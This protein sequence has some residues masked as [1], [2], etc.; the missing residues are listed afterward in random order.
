MP[1][2]VDVS[3]PAPGRWDAVVVGSGIGGLTAGALYATTGRRVLVLERN[4]SF[5]GAASVYR[6]G[7]LTIEASL[8]ELDGLDD[9]DVKAPIFDRLGVRDAIEFVDVGDLYEVRSRLLEEPFR[10]PHGVEAATAALAARFPRHARSFHTYFARLLAVRRVYT[11]VGRSRAKP[12]WWRILDAPLF[13]WRT[14]ALVRHGKASLA[15]V[16]GSAV[17]DD[18]PAKLA[19]AAHIGYYGDDARRLWFPF[20]AV[21]QGAYHAG[22]GHYPRGGSKRLAEHLISVIRAAGG[23]ARAGR[24]VTAIEVEHGRTAGVAHTGADGDEPERE[25]APVVFG[26]AAPAVLAELLPSSARA[27]FVAAYEDLAPSVSLFTLALGLD[28]RPREVGIAGWSTVL[29]PDWMRTLAV[30]PQNTT[31]LREPP[32]GRIPYLVVV[33][34]NA[35][36]SGLTPEPPHLLTVTGVDRGANWEE[37]PDGY[38]ERRARWTEAI[39]AALERE[40]PGLAAAVVQRELTTGRSV[41]SYLNAPDGAVYGFATEPPRKGRLVRSRE[42]TAI[43]GLYLASAYT[44]FGG[45]T[46]S[47]MGGTLAFSAALK[48]ARSAA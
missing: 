12:R 18:E 15:D 38:Q 37:D 7:N 29:F 42:R 5:G 9:D 10:M 27:A 17:A 46:G 26:N 31:L 34:Y 30:M 39:V 14:R 25:R 13:P 19:L 40:Y 32:R 28:R 11:Y 36:D 4:A 20:W 44:R 8:H 24:A 16:L 22:G 41:A 45:Y 47:I 43:P 6:V 23:E 48:D 2:L 1:R 35:A 21:A 3:V 33:D